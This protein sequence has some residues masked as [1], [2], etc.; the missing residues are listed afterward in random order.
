MR[1]TFDLYMELMIERVISNVGLVFEVNQM[2][3]EFQ[4][5]IAMEKNNTLGY[6]Y[7]FHIQ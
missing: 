6:T 3:F 5:I 7:T 2:V 4:S 1:T